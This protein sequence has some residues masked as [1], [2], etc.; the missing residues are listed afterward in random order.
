MQISNSNIQAAFYA[1]QTNRKQNKLVNDVAAKQEA[2]SSQDNKALNNK[3]SNTKNK[4]LIYAFDGVHNPTR[5]NKNKIN[6]QNSEITLAQVDSGLHQESKNNNNI[7]GTLVSENQNFV[8]ATAIDTYSRHQE[9]E[10]SEHVSQV[11][12]VDLY[13]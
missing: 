12:G 7:R 9:L 5:A 13:A 4:A 8:V 3:K 1:N 2:Q 11:M 10:H 6:Q